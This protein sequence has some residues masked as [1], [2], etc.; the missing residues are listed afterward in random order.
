MYLTYTYY[1][2]NSCT[3]LYRNYDMHARIPIDK[4]FIAG[5]ISCYEREMIA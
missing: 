3:P 5:M 4:A 2:D 1:C